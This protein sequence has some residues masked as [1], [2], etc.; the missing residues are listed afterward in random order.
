VQHE[1]I[2]KL[3]DNKDNILLVLV[4]LALLIVAIADFNMISSIDK[5]VDFILDDLKNCR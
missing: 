4:L 2:K 3:Q 5:Q 1:F